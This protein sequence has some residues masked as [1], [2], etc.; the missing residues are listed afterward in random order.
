MRLLSRKPGQDPGGRDIELLDGIQ[1]IGYN[2]T[3][4]VCIQRRLRL[5]PIGMGVGVTVVGVGTRPT[6]W[7]GRRI[8]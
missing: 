8:P 7:S 5:L 2:K 1:V 6:G 3:W 4:T